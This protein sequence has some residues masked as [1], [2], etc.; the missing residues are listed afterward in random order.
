MRNLLLVLGA[1]A[2]K[3]SGLLCGGLCFGGGLAFGLKVEC[4]CECRMTWVYNAQGKG[5]GKAE[6]RGQGIMREN[7]GR[8][9]SRKAGISPQKNLVRRRLRPLHGLL[10]R[11]DLL[12]NRRS[13]LALLDADRHSV[14]GDFEL[15]SGLDFTGFGYEYDYEKEKWCGY[16]QCHSCGEDDPSAAACSASRARWSASRSAWAAASVAA[17]SRVAASTAGERG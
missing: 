13:I 1:R 12:L 17:A 4:E 8:S 6:E 7:G 16:R 10:L 5:G 2:L 11:H 3:R 15:D 14:R 9:R